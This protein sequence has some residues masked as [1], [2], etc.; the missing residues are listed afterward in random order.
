MAPE[1]EIDQELRGIVSVVGRPNVGKSTLFNRLTGTRR[2]IVDPKPGVTRDRLYGLVDW[3]GHQFRL[4]DTGGLDRETEDPLLVKM[5]R[6]VEV[7]VKESDLLVLLV[8]A[9][10]GLLPEDEEIARWLRTSGRPVIVAA[11]KVDI[12]RLE[13]LLGEFHAL[14]FEKVVGISAESGLG[15]ADLL[16]EILARLPEEGRVSPSVDAVRVAVVGKP[17]VGKS[18]LVNRISGEERSVVHEA[19][20]T[21][22]DTVDVLVTLEGRPRPYLLLDTAGLK[23]RKHW[24]D[25]VDAVA[26]GRVERVL[27]RADVAVVMLDASQPPSHQDAAIAGLAERAGC[28]VV[29]ALNKWDLVEDKEAAYGPLIQDVRHRLRHV[30]FAPIFTLSVKTGERVERLL[31]MVD[32]VAGNRA[33]RV[34]TGELNRVIH[35]M[36]ER[37][38]PPSQKGRPVKLRYVTQASA[39]PPTIVVFTGGAAKPPETYRRF[40]INRLREVFDFEGTPVRLRF[41]RGTGQKH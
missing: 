23:R 24:Q 13:S 39:N 35:Q 26:A 38:K 10:A 4:V 16:D 6:Q 2:S 32:R 18:S 30:D 40:L 29:L 36:M 11:N 21:T 15:V 22:R 31:H 3:R 28:A 19:P 34:P 8:D 5:R 9:R 20:G 33:F 12:P 27:G 41:R 7:G 1:T 25:K 37:V 17:N 14:G